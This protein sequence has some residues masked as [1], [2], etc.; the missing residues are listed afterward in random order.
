MPYTCDVVVIGAGLAGLTAA[1]HLQRA[2]LHTVILEQRATA[3]GLCG[4]Q[5]VDG[6]TF[7]LA[8][9]D[10]G[11]GLQREFAALGVQVRFHTVKTR[12]GFAPGVVHIPPDRTTARLLIRRP[13]AL[14]RLGWALRRLQ[15]GHA[16]CAACVAPCLPYEANPPAA[17]S[18]PR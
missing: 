9:N 2:G 1:L 3:G 17:A 5:T 8:C 10:F 16:R 15:R 12:L 4:T 11:Q 18:T 7:V 13:R 14:L 6:Y